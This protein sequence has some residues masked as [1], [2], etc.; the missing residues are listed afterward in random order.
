M[1]M[2]QMENWRPV[3][4]Y[5]GIYSVSDLGNVRAEDR[6]SACGRKLKS[7]PCKPNLRDGRYL[8]VGLC[9]DGKMTTFAVHVLVAHAF[10]GPRPHGQEINHKSGDK[11]DNG[12]RNLE[13]CSQKENIL[14][15]YR[16]GLS[17]IGS[18]HGRAKVTDDQVREIRSLAIPGQYSE[19]GKRYGL[20]GQQVK[21]IVLRKQWPHIE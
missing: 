5:E 15:A 1:A 4:G 16:I 19:I 21:R 20:T 13:Y 18:D 6:I 10:I 17:P 7:H 8:G 12:A 9:K 14:H 2:E 3:P 11:T